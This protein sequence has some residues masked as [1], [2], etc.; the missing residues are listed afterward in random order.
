MVSH[1]GPGAGDVIVVWPPTL[2]L[3]TD[4]H[5][6]TTQSFCRQNYEGTEQVIEGT[7]SG[8]TQK[9][10]GPRKEQLRPF[11]EIQVGTS[12]ESKGPESVSFC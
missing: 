12:L 9:L 4:F 3:L 6:S 10:Q 7:L 5:S 1:L 2:L 11:S 8:K